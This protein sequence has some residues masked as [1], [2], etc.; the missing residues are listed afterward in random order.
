MQVFYV[1]AVWCGLATARMRG[2]CIILPQWVPD[3][4]SPLVARLHALS[5]DGG[6]TFGDHVNSVNDIIPGAEHVWFHRPYERGPFVRTGDSL[7]PT[8]VTNM[9]KALDTDGDGRVSVAELDN[10]AHW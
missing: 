5:D 2:F 4:V 6:K 7:A 9:M 3:L 1:H 8:L 10:V